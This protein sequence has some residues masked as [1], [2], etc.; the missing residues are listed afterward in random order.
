MTHPRLS[1]PVVGDHGTKIMVQ[2]LKEERIRDPDAAW[3]DATDDPASF[4]SIVLTVTKPDGTTESYDMEPSDVAEFPDA[5]DPS[6]D[7]NPHTNP[8]DADAPGSGWYLAGG[9]VQYEA[10][11]GW[12]DQQDL[13]K[14]K[15][16]VT[17]SAGSWSSPGLRDTTFRVY[18]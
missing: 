17:T 16:T 11:S 14:T 3:F 4:D 12:F 2:L 15:I 13:W 9:W 7:A 8:A 5:P 10:G 18:P 6:V 1:R